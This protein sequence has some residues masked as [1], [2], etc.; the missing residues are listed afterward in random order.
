MN[1][2][3]F[4]KK[5]VLPPDFEAPRRLTYEGLVA[6]AL[7]RSHLDDDVRG[8]NASI[9]LIQRTRGGA[10]P[11]GPVAEEEDFADLVWHE[12]EF[13]DAFSF[14]YAVY[15]AGGPYIGC[16]YLYPMGRR[17]ELTAELLDRDVDVS[18]WVIPDA[19]ER[20]LYAKLYVALQ[21][22][23]T[24]EFPFGAVHYSRTSASQRRPRSSMPEDA[25]CASPTPTTQMGWE[26][27]DIEATVRELRS[28]SVV[29]EE[30]DMPG[31][32]TVDGIAEIEGNYPSKG[33]GERG[34]WFRDSEGNMLGIGQ[35]VG[36]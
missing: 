6:E 9:E 17:T 4:T 18:W 19:Y 13:R 12:V 21:H 33:T 7:D 10:W 35:P 29:F 3:D 32:K 16:A 1:Y 23:L 2:A 15:E 25:T 14:S 31:L 30:Y 5:L 8:I 24:E 26:V 22:W 11:T 36:N 34:A 27:E 20:G 28:R